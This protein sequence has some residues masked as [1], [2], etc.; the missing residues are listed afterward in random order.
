[1]ANLNWRTHELKQSNGAT[2]EQNTFVGL[3]QHGTGS[4][5]LSAVRE[6][7]SVLKLSKGTKSDKRYNCCLFLFYL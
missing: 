3:K 2:G 5:F 7:K 4:E 1:M 6:H